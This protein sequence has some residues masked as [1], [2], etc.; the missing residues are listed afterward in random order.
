MGLWRRWLTGAVVLSTAGLACAAAAG[1][2]AVPP[3][4]LGQSTST[5]NAGRFSPENYTVSIGS[6]RPSLLQRLAVTGPGSDGA[7]WGTGGGGSLLVP[8][9]DIAWMPSDTP[10]GYVTTTLSTCSDGTT[11]T[12][13]V[14]ETPLAPTTFTGRS[15]PEFLGGSSV[16]QFR[17]PGEAPFVAD[18][19]VAGGPLRI[20]RSSIDSGIVAVSSG[21]YELGTLTRG[22]HQ[23]GILPASP[24]TVSWIF[25]VRALPVPISI[26]AP[27]PSSARPGVVIRIPFRAS[28]DTAVSLNLADQSGTVV[29]S[30]GPLQVSAGTH[31]AFWDGR[32]ALLRDVP[33]G[34]YSV[35]LT[36]TDPS[37]LGSRGAA[38]VIIDS[39]PPTASV[40][41]PSISP[42]EAIGIALSDG[43]SGLQKR[44]VRLNGRDITQKLALGPDGMLRYRPQG[45]LDVGLHRLSLQGTDAAGN[46]VDTVG[47][48]R[49]RGRALSRVRYRR[50]GPLLAVSGVSG[51]TGLLTVSHLRG[52]TVLSRCRRQVEAGSAFACLLRLD[53]ARPPRPSDR[54][55]MHAAS[56]A[57]QSETRI[58]RRLG[59]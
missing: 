40:L 26:E 33:D 48:V 6:P 43:L 12:I 36:S 54:I 8:A 10:S 25:T 2:A 4:S 42:R 5:C 14:F 23:R 50:S 57:I 24:A 45:P 22:T 20:R 31:D 55:E 39:T 15:S 51:L 17:V 3:T 58:R 32:D 56:R 53:R 35:A 11:A 37:G 38:T 21:S 29:R 7:G 18:V 59:K 46:A 1:T 13:D 16:V 41:T 9:G 44:R 27:V 30:L 28:G 52:G 34:I 49:V 19:T 47:T